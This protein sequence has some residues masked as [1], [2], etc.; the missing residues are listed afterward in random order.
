MTDARRCTRGSIWAKAERALLNM[1]A[2]RPFSS[3]ITFARHSCPN[4]GRDA[5]ARA[6]AVRSLFTRLAAVEV[7]LH[8]MTRVVA[9][10]EAVMTR[11]ART[12]TNGAGAPSAC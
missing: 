2:E 3:W 6:E 5:N 4:A 1:R 9:G 12:A 10:L 8:G 7:E 11:C